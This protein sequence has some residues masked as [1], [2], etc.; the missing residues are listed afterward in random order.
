M[1]TF[2][3]SS[4]SSTPP[5]SL[6]RSEQETLGQLA[7]DLDQRV[8]ISSSETRSQVHEVVGGQ[9]GTDPW[10]QHGAIWASKQN[11]SLSI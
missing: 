10:T 11:N 2:T 1:S 9:S 6:S 7:Q 8:H 4:S 5:T 3:G